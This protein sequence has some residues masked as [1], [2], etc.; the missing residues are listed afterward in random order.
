M[1][2]LLNW[3]IFPPNQSLRGNE[4]QHRTTMK[5]T[6]TTTLKTGS[7]TTATGDAEAR[8]L[9]TLRRREHFVSYFWFW[10]IVAC[11][12]VFLWYSTRIYRAALPWH[13]LE[14]EAFEEARE[15]KWPYRFVFV[16][17]EWRTRIQLH[18]D[19][20]CVETESKSLSWWWILHRLG[21]SEIHL[22]I[23]FC[24]TWLRDYRR[25]WKRKGWHTSESSTP[26]F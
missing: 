15:N 17:Y 16:T 9:N 2:S 13:Q 4:K 8:K 1:T 7:Q 23:R 19:S 18:P 21:S 25:S 11:G 10:F 14:S 26:R 5:T 6:T 20:T 22:L 12:G 3:L 24:K